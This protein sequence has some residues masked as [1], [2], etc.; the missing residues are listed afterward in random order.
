MGLVQ[1]I[2]AATAGPGVVYKLALQVRTSKY[3]VV[4]GVEHASKLSSIRNWSTWS[5]LLGLKLFRAGV[6]WI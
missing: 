3:P 5:S 2:S 1:S 4:L 6:E